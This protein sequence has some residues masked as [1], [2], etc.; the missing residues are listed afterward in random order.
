VARATAALS[1]DSPD[2]HTPSTVFCMGAGNYFEP[3]GV[4]GVRNL[5]RYSPYVYAGDKKGGARY[6]LLPFN[7]YGNSLSLNPAGF[8]R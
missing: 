8:W 4:R 2:P 5:P 6:E 3:L 1:Q 7:V